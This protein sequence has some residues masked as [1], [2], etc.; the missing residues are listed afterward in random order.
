MF[1]IKREIY[2][3][4]ILYSHAQWKLWYVDSREVYDIASQ[5]LYINTIYDAKK[6]IKSGNAHFP[7]VTLILRVTAWRKSKELKQSLERRGNKAIIK[8]N[9]NRDLYKTNWSC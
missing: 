7:R 9:L 8:L 5:T 6:V 4:E 2:T 1:L 3:H